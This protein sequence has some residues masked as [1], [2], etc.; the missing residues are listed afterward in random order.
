MTK[1]NYRLFDLAVFTLIACVVE[2][3]NVL[4]FNLMKVQVGK[5]SLNQVYTLSFACMLGMIA[6]YR[7]NAYGLF[8]APLAGIV[9][10]CCRMFLQQSVTTN[11]WLSFSIGYLGLA[12]C[13]LFFY[14]KDKDKLRQD[15]GKMILYYLAGFLSVEVVRAF[16]QIGAEDYWLLL[17][18]Y[19]SFDM[20]NIVFGGLVFYIALRQE[21]LVVD[22]E[23]YLRHMKNAQQKVAGQEF[24][25]KNINI[26]VEELAEAD[27]I[28]EA[29]I[30]DGGTL[31]TEDLKKMEDN[32]RKF[33]NRQTKFD[34]ENQELEAYR[35][36]KEAKHG[37]R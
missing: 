14:K 30:L 19:V 5:Y 10:I 35:K 3:I 28:N 20:I 34:Q 12:T 21:G 8:V 36:A 13:L 31:S 6:I 22:M 7:W 16:C 17:L 23:S 25:S 15:K 18:N 2:G 37:S 27:E 4:V 33:E 26:N 11:L 29:A 24:A 32:R 1:Q 9:S